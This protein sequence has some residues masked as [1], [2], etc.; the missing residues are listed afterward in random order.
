MNWNLPS[1][2]KSYKKLFVVKLYTCEHYFNFYNFEDGSIHVCTRDGCKNTRKNISRGGR[3]VVRTRNPPDTTTAAV[4]GGFLRPPL[5]VP[6]G[7][8]LTVPGVCSQIYGDGYIP[9]ETDFMVVEQHPTLLN[10]TLHS[11]KVSVPA[12]NKPR[13]KPW[14]PPWMG[15][16]RTDT[17]TVGTGRADSGST[18]NWRRDGSRVYSVG[19]GALLRS[20]A[21]PRATD[22]AVM[23]AWAAAAATAVWSVCHR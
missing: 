12:G 21:C 10:V 23:A 1:N 5:P 2:V 16:L 18:R 20:A 9:K 17:I 6:A 3:G 22:G 4:D 8:S 14:Q 11:S 13:L 15:D 7:R 19:G